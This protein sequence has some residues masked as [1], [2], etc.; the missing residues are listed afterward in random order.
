MNRY[1]PYLHYHDPRSIVLAAPVFAPEQHQRPHVQCRP[2]LV[3]KRAALAGRRHVMHGEIVIGGGARQR[4]V[5][6][7]REPVKRS[8]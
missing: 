1:P 7:T 5:R 4:G 2:A 8:A 3:R 6:Q